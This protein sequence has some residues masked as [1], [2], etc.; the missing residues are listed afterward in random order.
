MKLISLRRRV[1]SAATER[2]TFT[3]YSFNN[4]REATADMRHDVKGAK[5]RTSDRELK[6]SGAIKR[7]WK[8][9][10]GR[11]PV[12]FLFERGHGYLVLKYAHKKETEHLLFLPFLVILLLLRLT[13]KPNSTGLSY[14]EGAPGNRKVD[15]L[16]EAR[17]ADG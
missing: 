12:P 16:T 3:E 5:R 9:N 4:S 15:V 10:G 11:Q 14:S 6:R 2:K 13:A 1:K 8:N 17:Y 7:G